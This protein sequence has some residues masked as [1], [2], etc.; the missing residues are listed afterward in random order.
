[1]QGM[2]GLNWTVMPGKRGKEPPKARR[3]ETY[4]SSQSYQHH[5]QVLKISR[6]SIEASMLNREAR[7]VL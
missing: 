6:L 4:R 3:D 1:M 5:L 7:E 2:K